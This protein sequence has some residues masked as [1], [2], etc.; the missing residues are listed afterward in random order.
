MGDAMQGVRTCLG[1][2]AQ[3]K[4]SCR[5]ML[6]TPFLFSVV[7]VL[8]ALWLLVSVFNTD[9]NNHKAGNTDTTE[10]K[11]DNKTVTQ[12]QSLRQ[13]APVPLALILCRPRVACLGLGPA[14]P[15]LIRM[16]PTAE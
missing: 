11:N 5:N 15:E 2:V 14:V 1:L 8:P 16:L 4:Q 7:S 3:V 10:T 13:A 9:T 12:T 6:T